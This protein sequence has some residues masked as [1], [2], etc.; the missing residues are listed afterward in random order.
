M[1]EEEEM[2]ILK[3]SNIQKSINNYEVQYNKISKENNFNVPIFTN[4]TI[5][6]KKLVEEASRNIFAKSKKVDK[7]KDNKSKAQYNKS[8]D[9]TSKSQDQYNKTKDQFNKTKDKTSKSQDK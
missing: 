4:S 7:S 2:R 8:K 6:S 9:K 5:S 3:E 1:R